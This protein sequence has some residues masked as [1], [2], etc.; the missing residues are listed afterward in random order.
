MATVIHKSGLREKV[1]T[2]KELL[3]AEAVRLFPAVLELAREIHEL[4]AEVR[5]L[6]GAEAAKAAPRSKLFIV[7]R[8]ALA[9]DAVCA[10]IE[11]RM[12][13]IKKGGMR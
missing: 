6:R 1:P 5:A 13:T 2:R 8:R 3:K 4:R 9:I 12:R 10:G 11:T 7:E